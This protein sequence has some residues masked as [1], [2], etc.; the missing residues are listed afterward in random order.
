MKKKL[1]S[2]VGLLFLA[3]TLILVGCGD[4]NN[5]TEPPADSQN[6]ALASTGMLILKVNPEIAIAYN[7]TG[8][9]TE[10]KG[11]NSEGEA[12][13]EGYSDYIGKDSGVVLEELIAMIGEAGYFVEEIEGESKHIVLELEPGS[14]LPTDNFL[15]R[16][17]TNAQ[18]AVQ[19]YKLN[20]DVT[21]D[22]QT[23]ISLDEAKRIAFEHAGVDG[24][25]AQ[26]D[27][28]ELDSDAGVLKY[29]LEFNVGRN[30]YEY[31]IEAFTGEILK[32]EQDIKDDAGRQTSDDG[33]T[34]SPRQET[35]QLTEEEAL[36]IALDH[37]GLTRSQVNIE[38]LELDTDDGRLKWEI[39]FKSNNREYEFDI[40][41][42]TG[43]IFDFKEEVED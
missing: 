24:S 9:V 36:N 20:S 2:T 7:D 15:Q 8:E 4:M 34:S 41:A 32:Y 13:V 17:A 6:G 22:D 1:F 29:E 18:R 5:A 11:L 33:R 43:E 28:E 37:V 3:L 10:V 14:V 25:Q 42:R 16:V 27:D 30:E 19:E 23:L 21:V 26:F 39:N 35:E 40:D 31:D 12:I 38:D